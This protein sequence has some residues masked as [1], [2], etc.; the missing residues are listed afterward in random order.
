[1]DAD[2]SWT[3]VQVAHGDGCFKNA[4]SANRCQHF[5]MLSA[6]C[7]L[8]AYKSVSKCDPI[9]VRGHTELETRSSGR[10]FT[11]DRFQTSLLGYR[12]PPF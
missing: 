6:S 3:V 2:L 5:D 1:M 11:V 12:V 4:L 10:Y 7:Q 8:F 9:E